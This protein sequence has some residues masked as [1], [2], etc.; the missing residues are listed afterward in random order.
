M[1]GPHGSPVPTRV[2]TQPVTCHDYSRRH[3]PRTISVSGVLETPHH[4]RA[5]YLS[6]QLA[7]FEI[8]FQY[9]FFY[10]L[11]GIN[12]VY[13]LI[14]HYCEIPGDK[15][16]RIVNERG[17]GGAE[18]VVCVGRASEG[19]PDLDSRIGEGVYPQPPAN[20]IQCKISV[21]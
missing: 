1:L 13:R 15:R 7:A 10:I 14:L 2:R 16:V 12:I 17:G 8:T 4:P 5:Y 3:G 19:R 11:D 9:C 20:H 6:C 18:Y 21:F